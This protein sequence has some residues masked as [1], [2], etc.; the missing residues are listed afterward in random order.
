MW[1]TLFFVFLFKKN[2]LITP[3]AFR[4]YYFGPA[5]F[6]N[7]SRPFQ[8]ELPFSEILSMFSLILKYDSHILYF[9]WLLKYQ[10]QN[11]KIA[12]KIAQ[13]KSIFNCKQFPP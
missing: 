10:K 3:D 13:N 1:V 5:V 6:F 7:P 9:L 4:Y 8:C 11:L 2:A 12:F